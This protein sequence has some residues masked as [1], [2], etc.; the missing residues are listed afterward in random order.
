MSETSEIYLLEYL[1]R[2]SVKNK[3]KTVMMLTAIL[4]KKNVASLLVVGSVALVA[5]NAHEVLPVLKEYS[6]LNKSKSGLDS[7]IIPEVQLKLLFG[8]M[9]SQHETLSF[10]NFSSDSRHLRP[11]F[12]IT[13]KVPK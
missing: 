13:G 3:N 8:F 10:W 1:W 12:L 9:I 6:S 7:I 2:L 11:E 4:Y 5:W